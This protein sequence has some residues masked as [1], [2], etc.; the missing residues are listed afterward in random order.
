M[1][2]IHNEIN[3]IFRINCQ[4]FFYSLTFK[5]WQISY[6]FHIDCGILPKQPAAL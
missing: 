3:L 4:I 6:F 1:F 2:I 5:H